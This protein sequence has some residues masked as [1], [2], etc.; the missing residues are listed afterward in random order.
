MYSYLDQY[1]LIKAT[2]ADAPTFLQAQFGN[3]VRNVTD[4]NHQL[5]CYSTPKG[6]LLAI[7]RIFKFDD[8]YFLR[9]PQEIVEPTLQRLRMFVLMAKVELENISD[10][11]NGIGVSG[12]EAG[13]SLAAA[14]FANLPTEAGLAA[15]NGNSIVLRVPGVNERYEIFSD[16]ASVDALAA[17]LDGHI[18]RHDS[19][20]WMY[21]E[22]LAGIPSIY[23]GTRE[24]FIP[25]MANLEILD[26]LSFKKG[27]YPGQEIVARMHYLG[28]L[29]RRMYRFDLGTAEPPQPGSDVIDS[30][31]GKSVGTIV[32]AR[33]IDGVSTIALAVMQIA[34]VEQNAD[35]L[36]SADGSSMQLADLP[37]TL[38]TE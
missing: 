24:E 30:D 38:E 18:E 25:Q 7:F 26:G 29:K 27:C 15:S 33:K 17:Q 32:D 3:D 10:Q 23:E 19:D 13:S 12:P 34:S 28:K 21:D 11:W 5:N 8:A 22:I 36:T 9:M 1:G 4:E 20:R 37:D 16:R 31:S 6:R 2:G 14:G 35:K